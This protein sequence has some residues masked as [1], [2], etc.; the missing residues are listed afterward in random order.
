MVNHLL[1][2]FQD[3]DGDTPLHDAIAKKRD[4]IVSLLLEGG[5]D[6]T[7]S[8]NNG[9]NSLQHAALRGNPR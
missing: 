2:S 3:S 4:D 7:L 8:N 1:F 5:A 9:F 6:I